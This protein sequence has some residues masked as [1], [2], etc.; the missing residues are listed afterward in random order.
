MSKYDEISASPAA[1]EQWLDRIRNGEQ[2]VAGPSDLLF[3]TE[4]AY[5][6]SEN[7]NNLEWSAVQVHAFE[8]MANLFADSRSDGLLDAMR[9]RAHLI[10]KHGALAGDSLRDTD[11]I[12]AWF[13]AELPFGIEAAKQKIWAWK[14]GE[15]VLENASPLRQI[16]RRLRVLQ[17]LRMAGH[18]SPLPAE[19]EPWFAIESELV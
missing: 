3:V 10:A 12:V 4:I 11:S 7:W 15:R 2:T 14:E 6:R 13:F 16:R 19:L 1:A 8:L 18:L 9:V 5:S 17:V